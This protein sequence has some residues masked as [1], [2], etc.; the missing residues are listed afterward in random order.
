MSKIIIVFKNKLESTDTIL[1]ICHELNKKKKILFFCDNLQHQKI[2]D[3]NIFLKD[4][5]KSLG[6][7]I[8]IK[9][10]TN[11]FINYFYSIYFIIILFFELIN[12]SKIIHFGKIDIWP[13][14]LLNYFFSKNI[15][16]SQ[17]SSYYDERMKLKSKIYNIKINRKTS[18]GNIITFNKNFLNEFE[19]IKNKKIFLCEPPRLKKNWVN[20][21]IKSS[22]LYLS[23]FHKDIKSNEKYIVLPISSLNMEKFLDNK[24]YSKILIKM[25]NSLNKFFPNTKILIKPHPTTRIKELNKLIF[26][27][28]LK[29]LE[30]TYLNPNLL[31]AKAIFFITEIFGTPMIDAKKMGIK[32]IEFTKYN[33]T[34][35]K[36]TN[37][38]SIGGEHIDIFINYQTRSLNEALKKNFKKNKVIFS[39]N[40]KS[41]TKFLLH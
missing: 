19:D 22:E 39:R 17:S 15:I 13:F 3:Q 1:P 7:L 27:K 36:T 18:S 30:V 37:N 26:N 34:T 40:N 11:R 5:I 32:T 21:I 10:S 8:P 23:K 25:I 41:L 12:N 9:K 16:F 20:H 2:L 28:K 33:K 4:T 6:R 24:F 29:N 14:N 31:C 35:L 38:M